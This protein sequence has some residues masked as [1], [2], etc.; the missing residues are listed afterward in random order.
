MKRSSA[1]VIFEDKNGTWHCRF[2]LG[3][4]KLNEQ[5]RI[6]HDG[7]GCFHLNRCCYS[8]AE[9]T[10]FKNHLAFNFNNTKHKIILSSSINLLPIRDD[11][12]GMV[13]QCVAYIRKLQEDYK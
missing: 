2:C 11:I 10:R 1:V 12:S 4:R 3:I 9:G 7:S 5:Y 13:D 6:C 8:R